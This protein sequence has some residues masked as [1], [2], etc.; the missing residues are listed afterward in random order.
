MQDIMTLFDTRA[1]TDPDVTPRRRRW[2][3]L[4]GL[5]TATASHDLDALDVLI[6][7]AEGIAT[8]TEME[9]VLL[10]TLLF[11]GFPRTIEALA[12]LRKTHEKPQ[13]DHSAMKLD[14][15]KGEQTCRRIYADRYTRLLKNMDHLHPD[16]TDWMLADGYGRVLSRPGLDIETREI[17]V[18]AT[19]MA[20]GMLPQFKAHL[21]GCLNLGI[22]EQ[23][24]L[25][26]TN[27]FAPII[28]A[29]APGEFMRI[30]DALLR[31]EQPET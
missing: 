26:L 12:V 11:A 14:R 23:D 1:S 31:S 15:S 2:I 16:L 18:V 24:I 27:R 20:T 13:S 8:Q 29:D 30:R 21:R 25:W 22:S 5:A 4:A 28:A 9:E 19:L 17:C 10:Q 3:L 6:N 7:Q